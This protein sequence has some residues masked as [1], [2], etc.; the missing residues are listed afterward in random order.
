MED[1]SDF[2][3]NT[4][5]AF[6][7]H[8]SENPSLILVSPL[9]DGKNYHLWS[10]SMRLALSLKNKL[11]FIDGTLGIQTAEPL[12]GAWKRCTTMVLSWTQRSISE[13]IAKSILWI[14]KGC[15]ALKDLS[16]RF[17]QADIFRISE[18]Q[19]DLYKFQQGNLTISDYFTEMKCL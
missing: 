12:F 11:G 3:T 13:N 15:D 4:S 10:R 7:L 5:N 16:D 9:L 1:Y 6:Y 8:P 19:D 18:I 14:D 2:L 17:S